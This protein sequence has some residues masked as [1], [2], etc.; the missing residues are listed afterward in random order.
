MRNIR[1]LG[2][3]RVCLRIHKTHWLWWKKCSKRKMTKS[4]I[5][6][7]PL[8]SI[9][10]IKSRKW[11]RICKRKKKF[12][13]IIKETWTDNFHLIR[14]SYIAAWLRFN[15]RTS[16]PHACMKDIFRLRVSL[17]NLLTSWISK[18][19]IRCQSLNIA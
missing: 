18:K 9:N 11:C 7:L 15:F 14:R 19:W 13:K 8:F 1:K 4:I 6:K 10:R 17:R 2:S 5:I 16:L 12:L 3:S